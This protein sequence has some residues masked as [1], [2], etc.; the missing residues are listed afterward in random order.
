MA[1]V[2]GVSKHQVGL[3]GLAVMGANLARN[4]ERNGFSIAVFNRTWS[5]TEAFLQGPAAGAHG[6]SGYREMGE[7]C[8]ALQ[9]P[10]RV[11]VMVQAGA[12][13]DDMIQQ[14]LEHLEPGDT[15]MDGGNSYFPDTERRE[16]ELAAR[17]IH[18]LGTGISGGEEG[19]LWG[20]SIMP[21]GPRD[22]YASLE[23]VLTRIAAQ[24][25]DGP[26]CAYMGPGGA[27]HYVKM[28][29]NGIEYGD[30]QLICEAYAVL[31]QLAGLTAG[32]MAELFAEWNRGELDSYLIEI[33]HKVLAYVDPE[34]ERPLVDLILDRAGQ[35]GTGKWTSQEALDLGVPIPT[36]DASLWSRNIS[37]R[38]DERVAAS[39]RIAGPTAK[40]VDPA[41]RKR[42]IAA[43]ARALYASKVASYAQGLAMLAAASKEHGYHLDL[44]EIARI[45]KGGCIIRAQLLSRIQDAY[46]R[47]PALAN[48]L[49]D[50]YFSEV[51]S[52]H[53]QDWRHV[54]A[55]AIQ[56]GVP[57]P[58]TAASLAYVDAYRSA[59]L[60][61][62]L[63]QGLRD[64]FGAH[65]YE[66]IDRPGSFH[67]QW[68]AARES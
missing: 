10:R 54:V 48:L 16:K 63:L 68:E 3:V 17:G 34:T 18:F 42:L 58:A 25:S 64:F 60:P 8:A 9:R 28:V 46:R 21:G 33:A 59:R 12:P 22:A 14:L 15:I 27:G 65:T 62:N 13:V 57:V 7:F 67:T 41:E 55:T 26:C 43:V 1:G 37:A 44:I 29:H 6:L 49:L 39:G 51:I 2:N 20:P 11:I 52:S 5:R 50:P 45:W 31:S 35:K 53:E 61:A 36:I 56:H 4:I 24:V 32:E 19:A 30:I 40:P 66:R 38:K 47:D 23:P